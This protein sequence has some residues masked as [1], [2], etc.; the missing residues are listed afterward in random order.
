M[1][2]RLRDYTASVLVTMLSAAFGVL[3]LQ[4]TAVLTTLIAGDTIGEKES[5]QV[6]LSLVAAVFFTIAVYV[7]GVVTANTVGT[8]IAGRTRV[9][10]L[11]R[12]VGATATSLRRAVAVDGLIVGVVGSILGLGVASLISSVSVSV[13]VSTGAIPALSYE[14]FSPQLVAPVIAVVLVTWLA[15]W[16]GSKRIL[17]VTPIQAGAAAV[18]PSQ[19]ETASRAVRNATAFTLIGIGGVLLAGGVLLGQVSMLGVLVGLLG[20]ILSFSGIILGAPLFMPPI[21]RLVGR[22]LGRGPAGRIAAAN[23]IRN[24]ARSTRATIGL[25]IGV[26]LVTMFAVAAQS[27]VDII[28]ASR[29]AYPADYGDSD[30]VLALTITVFAVLFGFSALIAAVGM[31]N[32]LSLS[33]LQRT[34]EL[35]LL[36]ALGFTRGQIRRMI[37]AES[38]QMSV[39]AVGFGLVLGII[40]GW[41]GAMSLLGSIL[42]SDF[43]LPSVPWLVVVLAVVAAGVLSTAA[44]VAPSRR[45][46]RISPVAALAVE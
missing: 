4:G 30:Q 7:G 23:A 15:S 37:L 46:T 3:L 36:R 5:V 19:E 28:N 6:A 14:I 27:Y 40:Y 34:R 16:V 17:E 45:A 39:A 9:I 25:V 42:G 18:E 29:E 1:R 11:Y 22:M 38:I 13:G 10:A 12:L 31:V 2:M 35:G 43:S 41:A 33:V 24:P 8:V 32:N 20:G 26:T 21:L 44:S